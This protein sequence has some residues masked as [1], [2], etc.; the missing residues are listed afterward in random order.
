MLK[1]LN[2]KTKRNS[3]PMSEGKVLSDEVLML[4]LSQGNLEACSVLFERYHVRLYNFFLRSTQNQSLSQDL[5]QVVFERLLKYKSSYKNGKNFRSWIYQMARNAQADHFNKRQNRVSDFVQPDDTAALIK[6]VSSQI[7]AA[8][9]NE[10]LHR[11]LAKLNPEYREVI[12]LTK[13]QKIRGR[14]V[15]E[16]LECTEGAVKVKVHRA[17]KELRKQFFKLDTV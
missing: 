14:E 16:I 8:E 13:L 4:K 12:V 6:P 7:E 10:Q 2:Q 1:R 11:A 17:M 3:R 15:A 9:N 5:T